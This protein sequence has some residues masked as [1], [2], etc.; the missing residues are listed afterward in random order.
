MNN[1]ATTN[2]SM[3]GIEFDTLNDLVDRVVYVDVAQSINSA[4]TFTSIPSCSIPPVVGSHLTNKTYVDTK[5]SLTGEETIEGVKTFSSVPVC[6]TQPTTNNELANK[7]F[8]DTQINNL[9]GGAPDTLNT[10]NEIAE[11]LADQANFSDLVVYKANTQ[12]IDGNKTFSGTTTF[13]GNISA[14]TKTISP[15]E[16]GYLDGTTSNIQTQ[17]N[18]IKDGTVGD[19]IV[20]INTDETITG[21]KTFT[22]D[23]KILTGGET[24]SYL[25]LEENNNYG[26][27]LKYNGLANNIEIGSNLNTVENTYLRGA[28]DG[29]NLKLLTNSAT[30]Y[31]QTV[32]T[33]TLTNANNI[34]TATTTNTIQSN[35]T[36]GVGNEMKA[37]SGSYNYIASNRSL[38]ANLIDNT[39]NGYNWI[40]STGASGYNYIQAS[41]SAGRN[42][43]E[44]PADGSNLIRIGTTEKIK[45]EDTTTTL[46]N[47]NIN[48]VGAMTTTADVK[49]DGTGNTTQPSLIFRNDENIQRQND[50]QT[51]YDD[52]ENHI[53]RYADRDYK[54]SLG[55]TVPT[56]VLPTH[57]ITLGYNDDI[58]DVYPP[59]TL[60][61]PTNHSI[62]FDIMPYGA[63]TLQETLHLQPSKT[64]I[65][66]NNVT[67][68]E[69]T[70][71]TTTLTNTTNELRSDGSL[72]KNVMY[73]NGLGGENTLDGT[74]NYIKVANAVKVEIS[75]SAN[76]LTNGFNILTATT[77]NTLTSSLAY[78]IG[79]RLQTTGGADNLIRAGGTGA[80]NTIDAK[81]KTT[82]QT[83]GVNKV[84][85]DADGL[86]IIGDIRKNS[87]KFYHLIF[88]VY[89]RV[90]PVTSNYLEL[91]SQM[92]GAQNSIFALNVPFNFRIGAVS[93]SRDTDTA[94]PYDFYFEVRRMNKTTN[95]YVSVHSEASILSTNT[96]S[97]YSTS[98]FSN[99]NEFDSSTYNLAFY[100]FVAV[101]GS[102][103]PSFTSCASELVIK[104][105]AYQ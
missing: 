105:Y 89:Q 64:T 22:Q 32:N 93:L 34:L 92:G 83:D 38:T 72:G 57:K 65:K 74:K 15:T 14:N 97:S 96:G 98:L 30:K 44:C 80:E 87:V 95:A 31:E 49:L 86:D 42:I 58:Q 54:N 28:R 101:S 20:H 39:G 37:L 53:I 9:I 19:N 21:A 12:T 69:Q 90:S 4:K 52:R 36:N 11:A 23:V 41:G 91:S 29:Q 51:Y 16:L 24:S 82:F 73:A 63:S 88:D 46:T 1:S 35:A 50:S 79:N 7:I 100:M 78:G 6:S 60:D 40:R 77:E 59:E 18:D 56:Y 13:T 43:I 68:Y 2:L 62:K 47:N 10:L 103:P 33:T 67:K 71:T 81:V 99:Y 3:T 66:S 45:V 17:L 26:G 55:F 5:V 70:T 104:F 102:N 61:A 76:K 84:I 94:T 25:R 85:I 8:V 27:F 75:S 48:V